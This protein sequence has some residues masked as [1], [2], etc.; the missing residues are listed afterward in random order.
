MPLRPRL[1]EALGVPVYVD[2]DANAVALAERWFGAGKGA[3]TLLCLTVGVGIG[4]GVVV[5]GK[6][7]RGYKGGAGEIGHTLVEPDGPLCNCG[8]QG[9]LDA[10]A[11]DRAL[12]RQTGLTWPELVSRAQSG[13]PLV[14][15]VLSV[16]GRRIGIAVANSVNLLAPDRVVLGGERMLTAGNQLL[17][18][19]S[20][21]VQQHA[22]PALSS[23]PVVPWSVGI[24]GWVK[25]AAVLVL[26]EAFRAPVEQS[27]TVRPSLENKDV[28]EGGRT[29]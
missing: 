11:A 5:G 27:D 6:L 25:G 9:C 12:C 17:E 2:N 29:W 3:D 8:R 26:E 23:V 20:A 16:A 15:E 28:P 14:Q 18:S 22:F 4:G 19:V 13:D 24:D 7:H 21:T 1:A 10:V